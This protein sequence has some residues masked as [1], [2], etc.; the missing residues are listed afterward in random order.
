ML[1]IS[2]RRLAGIAVL[3][4]CFAWPA[5]SGFAD[6]AVAPSLP[7]RAMDRPAGPA[8]GLLAG[9]S[10]LDDTDDGGLLDGEDGGLLGGDDGGLLDGDDGGLLDANGAPPTT[11]SLFGDEA[12]AD[13]PAPTGTPDRGHAELFAESAYPS[14]ATCASCH[15]RQYGEWSVS[16]HAYAQLSPM[17]LSMQNA[18]NLRT[19]N[20]NGDFCLRCHAPVGS[21]LHEPLAASNLERHPASREGI[22][23][24]AC[25]R[26][27]RNFGKASGRISLVPG[28]I[29]SPVYGP[30]GNA[31]L[32]A[33]LAEPERFRVTADPAEP[34]RGIHASVERFFELTAPGFCGSCHDVTAPNGLRLEEA[35]SDYKAS[36]AAA[37][38]ITCQDCHMGRV[39]G[40]PD[41]YDV[42][43]AAVVGGEA[44]R[45]RRLTSHFFAGPDYSIV[46]PGIFPHDVEAS[47][48]KSLAEWLA[49]DV[50]AG[51]G[52]DAFEDVV[53]ADHVFPDAWRS[54]DDR[55]DGRAIVEA[56]LERLAWA[57]D[58]RL[59]V[60]RNAFD[61][62]EIR[63]GR[64]D[65]GG[66]AFEIDVRNVSAGHSMPI[67][68]D[69]ERIYFLRVT[70][71]D[72]D[73][74]VVFRS[75]DRD[76]NGD[77]RDRHSLYVRA[78]EVALDEQ[79]FSLQ[80]KFVVRLQR[81][82]EREQVLPVPVGLSVQP[83]VRPETRPSILHGQFRAA[84]KH[85]KGIAPLSHRTAAY[86][87]DGASL[88]GR[89]PYRVDIDF[90][91]QA[92]PVNLV[93]AVQAA[94]FDY[95]MTPRQVADR[96]VAG[97]LVVRRQTM[98]VEAAPR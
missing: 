98:Q 60:L 52:T 62:S 67:G 24:V 57:K 28:G 37:A 11:E 86:A 64:A 36:P 41:G 90:V 72:A 7:H 89:A 22:T 29:F 12:G 14:A 65:T 2:A 69:A 15:P 42:G 44:T 80:S 39:Q 53:P 26:V 82:A 31:G 81:G 63:V 6:D 47:R 49:F 35:F 61:L 16:Q 8:D 54:V 73:G 95:L 59:E 50:S 71:R 96:I 79:L 21:E 74:T 20:T 51:W 58:R 3:A 84:R 97:A 76:P 91:V 18:I 45:P 85:R 17:L 13:E 40:R 93:A 4:I 48:F 43:P 19:S 1:G 94:G 10:L 70:V 68:F 66:L 27:N 30:T 83:F 87:V 38:G 46:H 5:A 88:T 25:H 77:L 33:A 34:G 23:C 32:A 78:G 92:V 55:Y 9:D 56:Q 75:G